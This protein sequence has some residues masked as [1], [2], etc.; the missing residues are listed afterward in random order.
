MLEVE[1]NSERF[2]VNAK[3]TLISS[4]QMISEVQKEQF[5]LFEFFQLVKTQARKTYETKFSESSVNS[6]LNAF[7][8]QF[9]D[10]MCFYLVKVKSLLKEQDYKLLVEVRAC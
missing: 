3:N 4:A 1:Y 2:T 9:K 7:F 10:D 8:S 6:D 5:K